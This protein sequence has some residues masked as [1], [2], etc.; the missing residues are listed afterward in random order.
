MGAH[1][2]RRARTVADAERLPG[3]RERR[4]ERTEEHAAADDEVPRC[5]QLE[6]EE[7]ALLQRLELAAAARLPEIHLVDRRLRSQ[8]LEPVAVGD[9]DEELHR[10]QDD[11]RAVTAGRAA[12]AWVLSC[13]KC[14][15]T[16]T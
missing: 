14:L 9:A 7:L 11:A 4:E 3:E 6:Q 16:T 5:V 12:A 8:H 15:R 10:V 1:L 2:V 13:R